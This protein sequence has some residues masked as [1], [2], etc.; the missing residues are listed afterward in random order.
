MKELQTSSISALVLWL[1]WPAGAQKLDVVT[2][3]SPMADALVP[4]EIKRLANMAKVTVVVILVT[5][6]RSLLCVN[7]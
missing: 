5:N 6:P 2:T 4:E 1:E 3:K 7:Q